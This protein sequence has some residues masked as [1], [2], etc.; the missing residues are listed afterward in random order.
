M[1]TKLTKAKLH[2]V[3]IR[4]PHDIATKAAFAPLLY[5]AYSP[6]DLGRGGNSARWTVKGIGFDT[7]PKAPW[8]QYGCKAF[9]PDISQPLNKINKDATRDKA[10]AW[11]SENYG[12]TEWERSPFG[13]YHPKGTLAALNT[14][15]PSARLK[16]NYETTIKR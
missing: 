14:V 16:G 13:S 11:A 15:P 4:N 12:V 5:V 2:A 8:Y 10:L 6:Q 1:A 9:Y 7:H 3:G